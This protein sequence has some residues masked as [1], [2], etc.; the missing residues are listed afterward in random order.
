MNFIQSKGPF[1][2]FK[3]M[4]DGDISLKM[5]E[6]DQEKFKKQFRQIKSRNSKHK[7]EM[8][9]YTKNML[10]IFMIQDKKI[11]DLFNNYS[12]IKSEY[13]YGSNKMKLREK[14]LKY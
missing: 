12:K 3:K 2:L 5:A 14:D 1:S 11:I 8:Q 9:L 13:I 4:R 6:E 10:K 7:S